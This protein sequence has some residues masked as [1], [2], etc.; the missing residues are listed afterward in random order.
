M[1]TPIKYD[2]TEQTFPKPHFGGQSLPTGDSKLQDGKAGE[3]I[4][5]VGQPSRTLAH[6][7]LLRMDPARPPASSLR[8]RD[9]VGPPPRDQDVL[10]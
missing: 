1:S 2:F 10:D 3:A 5:I 9:L 4:D 7:Y 6:L 8:L